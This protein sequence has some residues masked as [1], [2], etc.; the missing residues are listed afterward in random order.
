MLPPAC[1]YPLTTMIQS[2]A[3]ALVMLLSLSKNRLMSAT[4]KDLYLLRHGQATHN[5]R[6]E[7]ARANGCLF[8]DFLELM[9]QDD[10]L[11]SEL[12][13]LGREQARSVFEKHGSN[14]HFRLIDLVVSSPLS[15]TMQTADLAVPLD[16]VTSNRVCYEDFRE[17]N[18]LLLN[19]QRKSLTDI[20]KTFPAWNL[21]HL[22]HEEDVLWTPELESN[23]S[24][25]ERGYQG[26][27][28]V[29]GRPEEKILVCAHGG[30]LSM[31]MA[32][33]SMVQVV[34][35][36]KSSTI[37]KNEDETKDVDVHPPRTAATRFENCELRRY[38]IQWGSSEG[39]EKRIVLTELD[40]DHEHIAGEEEEEEAKETMTSL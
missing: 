18:G 37:T 40:L 12:T 29:L 6:A 33:H 24:C 25:A 8:D 4:T 28:W 32:Q 10:S 21:E 31:V 15:R 14:R 30:I 17:I 23:E 20:R 3:V 19:A 39:D 34:D 16:Q 36:R 2:L 26:L 7:V 35:G 13:A 9:R 11:D 38:R 22:E 1:I 5:P 27:Q